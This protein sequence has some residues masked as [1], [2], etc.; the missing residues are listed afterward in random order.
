MEKKKDSCE[1]EGPPY[2]RLLAEHVFGQ[3]HPSS[4]SDNNMLLAVADS[5]KSSTLTA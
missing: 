3:Q 4:Q 5:D 1:G 2:L